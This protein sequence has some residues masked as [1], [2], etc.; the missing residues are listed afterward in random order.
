M[1]FADVDVWNMALSHLGISVQAQSLTPPDNSIQAQTGAF[2][3]P[4][5]RDQLLQ[6][7]P[8]QFAYTFIALA[9]EPLPSVSPIQAAPGW[10]YSYQ[11]PSDCLQPIA[12]TTAAGQRFSSQLWSGYWNPSIAP[13]ALPKIPYKVA[14]SQVNA[15][16]LAILCDFLSTGT[17][18][19]YLFYIQRVTNTG[20]FDPMF[21]DTLSYLLAW[22]GG[23]PLRAD[24]QKISDA[25]DNYIHARLET[26][27]Q[28]LN[29]SQQDL[30]ADSPSISI[31]G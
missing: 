10:P 8:W 4:K 3:F 24:K 26:L 21:C 18:P 5:C 14:E 25:K 27:A 15:G 20:M 19:L 16:S 1:S 6:N 7:A 23:G 13:R 30:E 28:H 2:W 22:K 12:V 31:R 29:A 9:Q 17:S 11:Y